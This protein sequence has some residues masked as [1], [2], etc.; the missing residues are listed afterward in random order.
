MAN[1]GVT[2]SVAAFSGSYTLDIGYAIG[3]QE[4]LIFVQFKY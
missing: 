3:A 1:D 2:K 4:H